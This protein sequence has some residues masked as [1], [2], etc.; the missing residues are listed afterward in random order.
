MPDES[1]KTEQPTPRRLEQA[2]KEG[3]IPSSRDLTQAVQLALAV[4][5]L[6]GLA[7]PLL[8]GLK[9]CYRGLFREAF[10]SGFEAGPWG[11]R[12]AAQAWGLLGGPLGVAGL[13]GMALLL[14]SLAMHMIQ[15]GFAITPK[16]LKLDFSRLNPA[17][18]LRELPAQNLRETIK[19][20]LLFPLFAWACW[21]VVRDNLEGFLGLPAQS[22]VAGAAVVAG[23]I[24]SLMWK[25]VAALLALG[26]LDYFRGR[27]SLRRKLR[28]TKLEVRQEQKDLE[29][30]PLIKARLRRL[31]RE[32][33]RRRM[34][35]RVPQSSVVV[36]NPTHYA[37]ALEYHLETMRAPV[38]TA[39]GLN[40]MA[41]RIRRLAEQ[42]GI[43][44]VENAPLA[45]ALYK[46]CQVGSEIPVALYRAVAEILAYIYRLAKR[47]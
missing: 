27:F 19:A 37:V 14:A 2:R 21:V 29:G 32:V 43:P 36:T 20:V 12:M 13:L 31:Q 45:Q 10:R 4:G 26:A 24:E 46:S 16:R 38:V 6:A 39:K 35:S 7:W 23:S 28:M 11:R 42:H 44:V 8:E 17:A 33:M 41:Q 5:L 30:N 40:Y 22:L 34:M 25:A 3:Q 15:T 1:Q 47:G 9:Q 18:R